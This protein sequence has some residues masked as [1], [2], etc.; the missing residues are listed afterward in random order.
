MKAYSFSSVGIFVGEY[1]C[2]K[3]PI[4]STI[5]GHDVF[6]LPADATWDAPPEY[7]A[8][9]QYAVWNGERWS[10]HNL[11]IEPE[12]PTPMNTFIPSPEQSAVS[13]MR[14]MFAQQLS[15]MEDDDVITYSG[16]A[17]DWQ[18]GKHTIGEVFNTRNGVHADGVAWDQT[19]EVFQDYDNDVYTDIKPGNSA[20]FT[21][22]RPLH[23][24][25]VAT[26]RPFVPVQG[27]HDQ[28]RIGEYTIWTDNL[29][30]KCLR[31]TA[32]SPGDNPSDWEQVPQ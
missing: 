26:A 19:W 21:F 7:D 8:E 27:S 31:D 15:S 2:Q 25:T 13:M 10:V 20:W 14:T 29:I 18:P 32:Y 9:T 22:N 11:D 23:G 24:K 28:Y 30:Y 17:N 3:D 1:E 4:R 16:L 12:P 6:L 5:E